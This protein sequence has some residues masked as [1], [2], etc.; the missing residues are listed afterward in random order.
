MEC[1]GNGRAHLVPRPRSQPWLD[2]AVG[3]AVW[4][5]TP[6]APLIAEI[7]LAA[8]AVQLVFTGADRGVEGGVEQQY[9]RALDL[10]DARRADVVLA[11]EMNGAPLLPQHGAPV[12]LVC[13]GWYGMTNVKWLAS[14]EAVAEPFAG[15]QQA[16]AYRLRVDAD[17]PGVP[18]ARMHPRA[19]LQPP[20]I[21]DFFTRRRMLALEPVTLT[22]RAWS[23]CPPITTVEVSTDGGCTWA[24]AD[25]E[26]PRHGSSAWQAWHFTWEPPAAGDYEL[27][28]RAADAAG[29]DHTTLP[30]WNAGGYASRLPHRVAVTVA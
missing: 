7:G 15:Y 1:A 28:C 8:D 23:G 4:T 3:T 13:P 6:L 19:L 5:G 21:P 20:G 17:D 29:N 30:A 22:G 10:A 14:I 12:R 9:A 16:H 25:V 2:E 26:P 27:C 18:L 11:Y 24:P